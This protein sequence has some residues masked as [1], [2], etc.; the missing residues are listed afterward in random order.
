MAVK[1]SGSLSMVTDI[2]GEFSGTAP[3]GLKEYYRNGSAGVSSQN[4]NVPTSGEIG[5]KDFYGAVLQF[6]HTI[7]S[8]QKQMN[9]NTYLVGQGWNG[10]DPV[11][12]T[13]ASN[14]YLWSDSTSVAGLT[15]PSNLNNKLTI[16]H[17]G[18]I[19][20]RGGNGGNA[21]ANG[22]AGGPAVSNSATGVVLHHYS[23][24]FIGGG[25]GGGAGAAYGG[26][27][28]GAGGGS[29]GNGTGANGSG[30]AGGAGGSIGQAG[31]SPPADGTTSGTPRSGYNWGGSDGGWGT[32]NGY[33]GGAGG[34]GAV[35]IDTGSSNG[36][37]GGGG[38]GGGRITTPSVQ[39]NL[40]ASGTSQLVT[41]SSQTSAGASYVTG[42]ASGAFGGKG[43]LRKGYLRTGSVPN[44]GANGSVGTRGFGSYG[45]EDGAGGGGGWGAAGG[46]SA[47]A[48]GGAGG[49]AWAGTN[50]ASNPTSSGTI[51]GTT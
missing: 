34:G 21:G 43:G 24:S 4:T 13:I 15:I 9:L 17:Y 32:R 49:A 6:S 37:W 12:L 42:T 2:V 45:G 14:V 5:F 7:S 22:G 27:G 46:R 35:A 31:S 40:I 47:S 25:G 48:S 29:G 16:H 18:K 30:R 10:A 41:T 38:G 1:S 11:V 33:G 28:G 44:G 20:G 8:N 50:W 3:H 19:I 36:I 26:G 51:Y 23:G 39:G